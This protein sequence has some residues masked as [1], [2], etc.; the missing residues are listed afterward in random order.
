[1]EVALLTCSPVLSSGEIVQD[2]QNHPPERA[3]FNER[4]QSLSRFD[5]RER[6]SDDRFDRIGL[7]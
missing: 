1:M 7:K 2:C 4:T 3:A 6:L 5:Q